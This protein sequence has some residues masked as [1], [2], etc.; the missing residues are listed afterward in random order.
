M[1]PLQLDSWKKMIQVIED[2]KQDHL[3]FREMLDELKG[4][5][6]KAD[7]QDPLLA[8]YWY[9]FWDSLA[10]FEIDLFHGPEVDYA[11]ILPAIEAMRI[12]LVEH[13]KVVTT[14]QSRSSHRNAS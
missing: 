13:L 10:Q 7:L 9:G 14:I 3:T 2:Y 6:D 1:T 11:P 5:M 8:E 4:L 12:F